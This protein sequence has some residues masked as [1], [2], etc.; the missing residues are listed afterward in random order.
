MK[1]AFGN[2][3]KVG[4]KIVYATGGGP[5]YVIGTIVKLYPRKN[6]PGKSYSPPDRVMVEPEKT[7]RS[8][9]FEKNP[10]VYASNVVSCEMFNG[11]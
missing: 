6:D 7:T 8:V 5:D 4:S 10:T 11:S 9:E 3:L 2:K 1:D